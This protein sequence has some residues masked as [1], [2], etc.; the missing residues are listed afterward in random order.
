MNNLIKLCSI[1]QLTKDQPLT[2]YLLAGVKLG[3][4]PTLAEHQ[5][6]AGLMGYLISQKIKDAGGKINERK[7]VLMLLVHDLSELFGGDIAAPL[8]RK[9]PELRVY[10]D[11][12]GE[13][14]I[15]L[16]GSYMSGNAQKEFSLLWK[17]MEEG[18]TDEAV[19]VKIID[20]M[21]HQLFLEHHNTKF[22][23]RPGT[24]PDYREK[25]VKKHI[26]SMTTKL[27]DLYTRNVMEAFLHEFF[28]NFYNKGFQSAMLM[29]EEE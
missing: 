28:S 4:V 20:Q 21:D 8:N 22:K 1:L 27:Q 7:V 29:D 9:Y 24:E 25:F 16:L 14:A 10:K 6:S 17:E 12:I 18:K 26:L 13:R 5:Y 3:E 23:Y 19:V 11:K 2:G 15:D